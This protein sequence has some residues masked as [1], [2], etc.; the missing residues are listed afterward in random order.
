VKVP[1]LEPTVLDVPLA[2]SLVEL[3]VPAVPLEPEAVVEPSVPPVE[4]ESELVA[5]L[6]APVPVQ[7]PETSDVVIRDAV[8]S[9][10]PEEP[11]PVAGLPT[12]ELE[13]VAEPAGLPVEEEPSLA[14]EEEVLILEQG[15]PAEAAASEGLL[16][17]DEQ[18]LIIE[19]I[20]EFDEVVPASDLTERT[21]FIE[22]QA[23]QLSEVDL[24][25]MLGEDTVASMV[26]QPDLPQELRPSGIP[27]VRPGRAPSR[28]TTEDDRRLV[29][30]IP[31]PLSRT[32]PAR[33]RP[34]LSEPSPEPG[35]VYVV[36][37]VSVM[38]PN[39]VSDRIFDQ[40][41]DIMIREGEALD[42]QF[43]ILKEGLQRVTPEWL[44][45]RKHVTGEIYGYV[46]DAG[47]A[48]TELRAKDRL[49][50]RTSN[51]NTSALN[52][53][54][55]IRRFFDNNLSD[56]D[57]ERIKLSDAVAETLANELLKVLK[58]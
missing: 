6:I 31:E 19:E 35:I 46:E 49:I 38:V 15:S 29:A 22:D 41:V 55:P 40:F 50:Y 32:E 43:L 56:L 9:L 16:P 42:L 11:A 23:E 36:P 8:S 14:V 53:Q 1:S 39:Q 2:P 54:Y 5:P 12:T 24:V 52:F 33:P 18:E 4:V 51:K 45:A 25:A 7:S 58:N 21:P 34:L 3:E 27:I 17:A 26:A 47:S 13:T 10:P 20:T 48:S 44:A 28:S 30:T 57:A 37:F